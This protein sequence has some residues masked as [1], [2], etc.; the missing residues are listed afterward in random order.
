MIRRLIS[1]VL[2]LVV[3]VCTVGVNYDAHYCGGEFVKSQLSFLPSTLSCGMKIDTKK[4]CDDTESFSRV[5]CSNEHV[6]FELGDDYRVDQVHA[7]AFVSNFTIPQSAIKEYEFVI[8]RTYSF[9]GYSPP[10]L[11]KNLVIINQ[12]F[13]I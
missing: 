13:L 4:K 8:E 3:L 6:S 9:L 5:C 7:P 10:P 1:G 2:V 12:S 11:E